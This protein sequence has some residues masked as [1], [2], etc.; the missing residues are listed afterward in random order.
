[1][2][3]LQR[4]VRFTLPTNQEYKFFPLFMRTLFSYPSFMNLPPNPSETWNH[5]EE[6]FKYSVLNLLEMLMPEGYTPFHIRVAIILGCLVICL[7]WWVVNFWNEIYIW[8]NL[9]FIQ[10]RFKRHNQLIKN[11]HKYLDSNFHLQAYFWK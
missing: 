8:L 2:H 7:K 9:N 4:M 5:L 10:F 3:G 6:R 1:M 11:D